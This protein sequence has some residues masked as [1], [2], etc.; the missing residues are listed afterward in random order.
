M[1][2][3]GKP[4]D[5]EVWSKQR[6]ECFFV[7]LTFGVSTPQRC[8]SKDLDPEKVQVGRGRKELGFRDGFEVQGP[9][10]KEVHEQQLKLQQNAV[11]DTG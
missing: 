8:G 9:D 7:A 1:H 5:A 6:G 10:P 11:G 2:Q 4:V 3:S